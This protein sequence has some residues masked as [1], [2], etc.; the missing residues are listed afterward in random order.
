MKI[1]HPFASGIFQCENSQGVFEKMYITGLS[2]NICEFKLFTYPINL[3][4]RVSQRTIYLTLLDVLDGGDIPINAILKIDEIET[5][6]YLGYTHSPVIICSYSTFLFTSSGA[7]IVLK[8]MN[9]TEA[10]IC[11]SFYPKSKMCQTQS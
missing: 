2:R 11:K 5:P 6:H 4:L 10:K 7:K 3:L 1:D 8:F 9:G